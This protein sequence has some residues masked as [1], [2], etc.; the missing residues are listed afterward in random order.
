MFFC[1]SLLISYIVLSKTLFVEHNQSILYISAVMSYLLSNYFGNKYEKKIKAFK[2]RIQDKYGDLEGVSVEELESILKKESVLFG[3]KT[4]DSEP[5]STE[6][7][8]L[9]IQYE[10]IDASVKICRFDS[11]ALHQSPSVRAL[12]ESYGISADSVFEVSECIGEVFT[13]DYLMPAI[14]KNIPRGYEINESLHEESLPTG[15]S[16]WLVSI[17][18]ALYS[19]YSEGYVFV[20]KSIK[21]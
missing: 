10:E 8:P 14:S 9:V 11:S 15:M 2:K 5:D 1:S 13:S 16:L 12:I 6:S 18:P 7:N 17:N 3:E 20:S 4:V 19:E 21:F